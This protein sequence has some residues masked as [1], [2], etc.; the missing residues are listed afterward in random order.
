MNS[1]MEVLVR[2]GEKENSRN[3]VEEESFLQ[4]RREEE[5]KR[6]P[7]E[8]AGQERLEKLTLLVALDGEARLAGERPAVDLGE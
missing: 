2:G 3:L 1:D 5:Y 7:E 6:G 8:G 4:L